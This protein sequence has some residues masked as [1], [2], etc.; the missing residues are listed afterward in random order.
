[1]PL[2]AAGVLFISRCAGCRARD[3]TGGTATASSHADRD[4]RD[5]VVYRGHTHPFVAIAM[6]VASL[7]GAAMALRVGMTAMP[8]C[9]AAPQLR[10]ARRGAGRFSLQIDELRPRAGRAHRVF[11]D[12]WI[13]AIT[14]TDVLAFLKLRGS[15]AASRCCCGA[16]C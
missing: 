7:I 13:G 8:E 1:M 12:V 5:A 9:G 11:I 3:R 10:R 4:R 14:T 15:S 16:T 6:I 2:L